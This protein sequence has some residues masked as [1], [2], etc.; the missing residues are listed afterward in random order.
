M[1]AG[2][3]ERIVGTY[4][5]ELRGLTGSVNALL[6]QERAQQKRL[7]NALGDLAHS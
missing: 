2:D 4:P 6:G 1:Q 5:S 7:R 3:R